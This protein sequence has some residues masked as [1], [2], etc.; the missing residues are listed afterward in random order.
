MALYTWKIIARPDHKNKN[1]IALILAKNRGLSTQKK[2]NDFL[3]PTLNQILEIK[4]KNTSKA[5]ERIQKAFKKKEKI[6]VYSD[7]DADG[8]CGT[9]ILW[10]TLYDL[11]ADVLPYVP[12][13][14]KEGYG[15]SNEAISQLAKKGTK[16][17]ITVDHGVAAIDQIDHAAK[18]GI[19]VVVTDHHVLPQRLPSALAVVHSTDLCGAGVAWRLAFEIIKKLKPSYKNFLLG[20]LELAALATIADLVPLLGA[21]RAIVKLGLEKLSQTK[22]PGI[23]ALIKA[24][25]LGPKIGTYEIGH[26][27]APRINAMGRIEHAID[28][29]RLLCAKNQDQAET[30]A[31]L[32]SKT[33][34]KRQSLTTKSLASAMN[35]ITE[36]QV[37]GVI[38]HDSWH[39]G[40]IG[41]VASRLVD[42]FHKPM[43]VISKGEVYS[44]ASARSIAG[45]NIL[46]AIQQSSQ[47]IVEAGGH[48]M[49]A[50]FTI[51]TSHIQNFS[52]SINQYAKQR[53]A[54]ELLVPKLSIECELKSEDINRKT[55]E[56][57]NQFEP[58]GMANPQ[59]LFLTRNMLVEDVRCVGAASDHLKLQLGVISAIGFN[60]GQMR[61]QIRPGYLVDTVYSISE[62][63]Y[64]GNGAIQLKL[65]DLSVSNP[66]NL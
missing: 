41:L 22:R 28:S 31:Q 12:H 20:K 55:L 16:L 23:L 18:L 52:E 51:K 8:I 37:I 57:V 11:G 29:L 61:I 64:N 30:L 66:T 27:L 10:E 40:I 49:A 26:I 5:V 56:I 44:K 58:Y 65:K 6:I 62:D 4:P 45:F 3:K 35:M 53:L 42:S 13:R 59:P 19:D 36:D 25:S 39:E 38:S 50:G 17:I 34:T 21:N 9:A 46:E 48:P 47:L 24:A 54:E 63:R 60:L 14:V 7:Y 1:W 43:I 15:L 33:N 32:L 2:L